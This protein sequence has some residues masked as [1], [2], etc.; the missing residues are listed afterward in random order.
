MAKNHDALVALVGILPSISKTDLSL[1]N[2]TD[3]PRYHAL[4][5]ILNEMRGGPYE[6]N[7]SGTDELTMTH[8]SIMLEACNTSFQVHFQ[9]DPDHFAKWYNIAQLATAPVLAASVNSPV[10]L[11]RRL[12]R[13][14]RI[15][16]FQQSIDTRHAQS[17][18]RQLPAR[19]SFGNDWIKE[20]VLEIFQEDIAR[21]KP[22]FHDLPDEDPLEVIAAGGVPELA[23]LVVAGGKTITAFRES[24]STLAP[25]N[26][27][28]P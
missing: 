16:V 19:V 1:D 17:G 28:P 21:F 14:T 25:L 10:L 3:R 4:N 12:W 11:G 7:I 26:I 9:V 18:I 5:Q 8:D 2:L 13:E 27:R 23:A 6:L 20:S 15:A 22:I 24:P